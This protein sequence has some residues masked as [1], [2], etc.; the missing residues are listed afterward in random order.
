MI[1]LSFEDI[2]IWV[3]QVPEF[4]ERISN[5]LECPFDKVE[6]LV[7]SKVYWWEQGDIDSIVLSRWGSPQNI[8]R[9]RGGEPL[10]K[11]DRNILS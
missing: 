5:R 4:Y 6:E 3:E 8:R 9:G 10:M 2:S 7:D 1:R 11:P